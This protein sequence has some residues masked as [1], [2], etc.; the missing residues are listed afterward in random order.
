[1]ETL[2]HAPLSAQM[3]ARFVRQGTARTCDRPVAVVLQ[4][5]GNL[6][7]RINRGDYAAD[8]ILS[9]IGNHAA[10][11]FTLGVVA[12]QYGVAAVPRFAEALVA[13]EE[14]GGHWR[15]AAVGLGSADPAG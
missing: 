9:I 1:M 8:L 14:F 6:P 7:L 4:P 10:M 15:A 2:P 13:P 12:S 5:C 11:Q 3:P